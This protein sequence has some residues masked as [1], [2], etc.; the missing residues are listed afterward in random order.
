MA[1]VKNAY[2]RADIAGQYPLTAAD[3][4]RSYT[5]PLLASSNQRALPDIESARSVKMN[6]SCF[7]VIFPHVPFRPRLL[8]WL[9]SQKCMP[10]R[11]FW[12]VMP[13]NSRQGARPYTHALQTSQNHGA[14]RNIGRTRAEHRHVCV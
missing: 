8:S 9:A 2:Q 1:P 7:D 11:G 4:V 3:R 10:A 14:P 12:L 5:R 6:F 13:T